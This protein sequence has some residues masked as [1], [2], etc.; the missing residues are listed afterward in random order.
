VPVHFARERLGSLPL[1]VQAHREEPLP[2]GGVDKWYRLPRMVSHPVY[3]LHSETRVSGGVE[4][5]T[6]LHYSI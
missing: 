4:G 5:L 2:P 3:L 6:S 1:E